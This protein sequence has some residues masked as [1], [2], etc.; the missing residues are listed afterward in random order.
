M[1]RNK[2]LILFVVFSMGVLTQCDSAQLKKQLSDAEAIDNSTAE[3]AQLLFGDLNGISAISV[4]AVNEGS[5]FISSKASFDNSTVGG[6]IDTVYSRYTFEEGSLPEGDVVDSVNA[7]TLIKTRVPAAIEY[8]TGVD[9]TSAVNSAGSCKEV[10]QYTYEQTRALLTDEQRIKYDNE[11]Y[12]LS[13]IDDTVSGSGQD[14]LPTDPYSLIS[15]TGTHLE[16][17]SPSLESSFD[18]EIQDDLSIIDNIL[19]QYGSKYCKAISAQNML[20]WMTENAFDSNPSLVVSDPTPVITCDDVDNSVGSCYWHL[21]IEY[22][23]TVFADSYFCEDFIGTDY[24]GG[25]GGKAETKCLDTRVGV[26]VDGVK[27]ADRTDIAEID[28]TTGLCA[29]DE[30]DEGAYTWTQYEPDNETNCPK[31]FFI[32]E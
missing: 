17:S 29:I 3:Y 13:F 18:P 21:Y 26:Y 12:Q 2:L 28:T 15:D 31:R 4:V 20:I 5:N 27:C 25:V 14:W 23:G 6:P 10:N 8:I 9:Y 7:I 11:G 30:T 16:I 24:T 22:G 19:N 1:I 32:C